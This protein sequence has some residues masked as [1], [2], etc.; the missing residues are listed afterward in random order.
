M[1]KT[2]DEDMVADKCSIFSTELERLAEVAASLYS[3]SEETSL[4]VSARIAM[5]HQML[6]P[7]PASRNT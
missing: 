3:I 6:K 1:S 2:F 7:C 5:T 4:S